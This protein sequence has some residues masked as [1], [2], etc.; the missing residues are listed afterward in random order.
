MSGFQAPQMARSYYDFERA[1]EVLATE[2]GRRADR[3]F[4]EYYRHYDALENEEWKD[5][6]K[7]QADKFIAEALIVLRRHAKRW[8]RDLLY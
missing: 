5:V 1:L 8:C 6:S 3:K 2:E 4:Q 7:R